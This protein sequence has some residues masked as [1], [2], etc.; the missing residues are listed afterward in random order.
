MMFGTR[1]HINIPRNNQ[2]KW[3]YISKSGICLV[4]F[5]PWH[6]F[7][8]HWN[9]KT[10]SSQIDFKLF[11]ASSSPCHWACVRLCNKKRPL[12]SH[13]LLTTTCNSIQL[14][15]PQFFFLSFSTLHP[16]VFFGLTCFFPWRT[17]SKQ[18]RCCCFYEGRGLSISNSSFC[19]FDILSGQ[20]VY[21]GTSRFLESIFD[22]TYWDFPHRSRW[23][24]RVQSN[25]VTQRWHL[26]WI[27]SVKLSNTH[28]QKPD[29]VF[30]NLTWKIIYWY[31]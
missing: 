22:G 27:F 19:W 18:F 16:Q 21:L 3:V 12:M 11:L 31:L 8:K 29:H 24:S 9:L 26:C 14:C 10:Q 30:V 5:L 13:Q 17:K 4:I 15:H 25:T 23:F 20:L 2:Y 28:I 6:S 7:Y 1:L